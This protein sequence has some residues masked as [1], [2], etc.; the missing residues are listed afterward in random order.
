M[1]FALIKDLTGM[2][3]YGNIPEIFEADPSQYEKY[4][5]SEEDRDFLMDD[6]VSEINEITGALLDYG[7]IDFLDS[8]RCKET[9]D[10][11]E[12]RIKEGVDD[13]HKDLCL[14]LLRYMNE[15][16]RL[17]TGVVIEL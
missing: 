13:V 8:S 5:F 16:V 12:N 7:D 15:A 11:L 6:Y 2:E 17:D 3:Y 1:Y 4:T 14:T 9:S 10:W